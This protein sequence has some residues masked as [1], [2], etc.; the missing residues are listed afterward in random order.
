VAATVS[1]E[2]GL[3]DLPRP[4]FAPTELRWTSYWTPDGATERVEPDEPVIGRGYGNEI[5]E[6]Q[7]CLRAGALTSELVPPVQT[8]SLMRQ[9]DDLRAQ[10][11]VTY[12]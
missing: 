9:M 4:F 12:A 11:G 7:R 2:I 10:T 6:V 5:V 1:T 8:I 3:F